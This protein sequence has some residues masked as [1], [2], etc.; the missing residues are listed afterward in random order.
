MALERGKRRD[1]GPR[2]AHRSPV[3]IQIVSNATFARSTDNVGLQS[4]ILGF[5]TSIRTLHVRA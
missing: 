2:L 5:T 1:G 3:V 4:L